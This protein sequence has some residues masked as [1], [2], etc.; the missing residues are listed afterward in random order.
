LADVASQFVHDW[1]VFPRSS[2]RVSRCCGDP[3]SSCLPPSA[4]AH[5]CSWPF[6]TAAGD[7]NADAARAVFAAARSE[8]VAVQP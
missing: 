5:L 2:R 7:T 3:L 4:G 1:L 6:G 8:H